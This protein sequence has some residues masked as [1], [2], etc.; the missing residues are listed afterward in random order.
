MATPVSATARTRRLTKRPDSP[1]GHVSTAALRPVNVGTRPLDSWASLDLDDGLLVSAPNKPPIPTFVRLSRLVEHDPQ[2]VSSGN[3][4]DLVM[5]VAKPE[6]PT[7]GGQQWADAVGRPLFQIGLA[8]LLAAAAVA[9]FSLTPPSPE[10]STAVENPESTVGR[11]GSAPPGID[12]FTASGTG[13]AVTLSGQS[14]SL[15]EAD[16]SIVG[17]ATAAEG[18]I[19]WTATVVNGGPR[20]D[21]GPITVKHSLA[22][23]LDLIRAT[24]TDWSCQADA[25]SPTIACTFAEALGTGERRQLA[26]VTSDGGTPAGTRLPSTMSVMGT[27]R[28]PDLGNNTIGVSAVS[29]GSSA[30]AGDQSRSTGQASGSAT[31][32]SEADSISA[33]SAGDGVGDELPRTGAGQTLVLTAFGTALCLVGRRM[34]RWSAS[35]PLLAPVPAGGDR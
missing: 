3:E 20:P 11:Q 19:R 27:G 17:T 2:P 26:V 30:G 5:D 34:V 24:G 9:L 23:G 13:E 22:P 10:G 31:N 4:S 16:L 8:A 1:A 6:T 14:S 12:R 35:E 32:T 18:E 29:F 25:G 21:P 7:G 28:D 33:G 15:D